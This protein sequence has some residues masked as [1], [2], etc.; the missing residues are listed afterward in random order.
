VGIRPEAFLKVAEVE[1][2]VK[3]AADVLW[4]EN[5][6][7]QFL[8]GVRT[9]D[10]NLNVLSHRRPEGEKIELEIRPENIH[11]FEKDSGAALIHRDRSGAPGS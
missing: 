8:I 9:A 4:V 11:V 3:L 2:A 7:V 1:N 6:G 5:L 10:L